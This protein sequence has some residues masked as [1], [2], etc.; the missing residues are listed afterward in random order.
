MKKIRIYGMK[1]LAMNTKRREKAIELGFDPDDL[2]IDP[3]TRKEAMLYPITRAVDVP[4]N[5]L[6][7]EV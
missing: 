7:Q 2:P 1:E 6:K 3:L 4:L 5:Y